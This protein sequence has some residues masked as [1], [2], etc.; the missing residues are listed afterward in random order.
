[1]YRKRVH[2]DATSPPAVDV[3]YYKCQQSTGLESRLFVWKII[4]TLCFLSSKLGALN[5][6]LLS[7]DNTAAKN[8][9]E[10]LPQNAALAVQNVEPL[11][12]T[13]YSSGLMR[14]EKNIMFLLSLEVPWNSLFLEACIKYGPWSW[15]LNTYGSIELSFDRFWETIW[16]GYLEVVPCCDIS[17]RN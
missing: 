4:I 14:L 17:T 7:F 2:Y 13:R 8:I 3:L 9:Y 10:K 5:M 1:M 12:F 11:V 16:V 6:N 15:S